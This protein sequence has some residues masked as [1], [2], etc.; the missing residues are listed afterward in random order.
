MELTSTNLLIARLSLW[1]RQGI[2]RGSSMQHPGE[3][4]F[5]QC[6]SKSKI[7]GGAG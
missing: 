4:Q 5:T 2:R 6:Q 7:L 3:A 1:L